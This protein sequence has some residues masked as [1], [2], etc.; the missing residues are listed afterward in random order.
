MKLIKYKNKELENVN[1][2]RLIGYS[3]ELPKYYCRKCGMRLVFKGL[4]E[5][6]PYAIGGAGGV[7]TPEKF[8]QETGKKIM[9]P[10]MQCPNFKPYTWWDNFSGLRDFNEDHETHWLQDFKMD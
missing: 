6:H 9:W 7:I 8:D 3:S 2:L 5:P 1:D 4:V 10:K